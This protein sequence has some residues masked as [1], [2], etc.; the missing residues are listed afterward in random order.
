DGSG[1]ARGE[2]MTQGQLPEACPVRVRRDVIDDDP[3]SKIR[4]SAA[5]AGLRAGRRA[6][7]RGYILRG[8]ARCRPVPEALALPV[9]D[10]DRAEH[11]VC[12]TLDELDD[13]REYP[14]Q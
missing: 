11:P 1:P 3:C 8:E 4:G 14:A 7:E 9:V 13:R 5:R 10:Q 12:L 2:P 6:V